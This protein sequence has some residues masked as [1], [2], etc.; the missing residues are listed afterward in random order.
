MPT[1][2]DNLIDNTKPEARPP[3][4][5]APAPPEPVAQPEPAPD[6]AKSNKLLGDLK[7]S[8]RNIREIGNLANVADV[9]IGKLESPQGSVRDIQKLITDHRIISPEQAQNLAEQIV[10]LEQSDLFKGLAT[11]I[12]QIFPEASDS[13]KDTYE[14]EIKKGFYEL[15]AC[16][17]MDAA[18][19][20]RLFS[21]INIAEKPPENITHAVASIKIANHKAELNLYKEFLTAEN[22]DRAHIIKH[23]TG[24][25]LAHLA[26]RDEI[27]A[28]N[29]VISSPDKVMDEKS[30]ANVLSPIQSY[31]LMMLRNPEGAASLEHRQGGHLKRELEKF[32]Q[33]KRDNPGD[34]A[35]ITR[36]QSDLA[37]E[38]IADRLAN[39]LESGGNLQ[40]YLALR[41][42]A[43]VMGNTD[44]TAF[45]RE[46]SLFEA[47]D[48]RLK[49]IPPTEADTQLWPDDYYDDWGAY[50]L[51]E[52]TPPLTDHIT[53]PTLAQQKKSVLSKLFDWL[54]GNKPLESS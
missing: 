48:T 44:E 8:Q 50:D 53:N 37:Q 49:Q 45:A 14:A 9:F 16:P 24:H 36:K 51:P 21:K 46:K 54:T 31:V 42:S 22:C 17:G 33:F 40:N 6:D 32:A 43:E 25:I 27:S 10:Q 26:L 28:I 39:Y 7:N 18:L 29:A 4:A 13:Q 47:L 41:F 34:A 38:I 52:P 20:S 30:P 23:E 35:G 12:E 2:D 15:L 5:I 3:E 1:N 19:I 11:Q